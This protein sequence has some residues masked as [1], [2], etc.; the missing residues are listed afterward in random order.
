MKLKGEQGMAIINTI[1]LF[2]CFLPF[3]QILITFLLILWGFSL[4][5]FRRATTSGFMKIYYSVIMICIL[6]L[7]CYRLIYL[8][9]IK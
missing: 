3:N 5:S 9:I 4:N 1:L 6:C 7:L 2:I 8:N